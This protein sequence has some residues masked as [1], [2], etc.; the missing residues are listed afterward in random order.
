MELWILSTWFWGGILSKFKQE[1]LWISPG[2]GGHS[3]RCWVHIAELASPSTLAEGLGCV[4]MTS[5][6]AKPP[7]QRHLDRILQAKG[8]RQGGQAFL[9]G[10]E[11]VPSGC[12]RG[13]L[14]EL[15]GGWR[16]WL[17]VKPSFSGGKFDKVG[18]GRRFLGGACWGKRYW[19][20]KIKLSSVFTQTSLLPF[21]S[22]S[23]AYSFLFPFLLPFLSFLPLFFIDLWS[24]YHKI[25]P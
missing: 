10:Q 24:L 7:I 12:G 14:H 15:Q 21:L 2:R 6:G 22:S 19:E 4:T 17:A 1:P 5:R 16:S 23:L 13:Q 8:P 11:D 3:W 25:H 20:G 18:R 9:L